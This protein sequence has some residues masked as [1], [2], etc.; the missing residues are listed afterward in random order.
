MIEYPAHSGPREVRKW[1]VS[2]R[3]ATHRLV[4]QGM[5]AKFL[6]AAPEGSDTWVVTLWFEVASDYEAE[7]DEPLRQFRFILGEPIPI[8]ANYLATLPMAD[9]RMILHLYE[10]Y[11]EEDE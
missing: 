2:A 3:T 7:P 4:A 1:T 6:H 11:S 5:P 8:G 10:T 9:P